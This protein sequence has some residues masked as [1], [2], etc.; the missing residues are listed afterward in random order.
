MALWELV[1]AW[2]SS[3]DNEPKSSIKPMKSAYLGPK[4]E[5]KDIE[6]A[7][8]DAKIDTKYHVVNQPSSA[9]IAKYLADGKI[10]ARFSGQM[11]FGQRALGNR[12]ILADPRRWDSVER[13]NSKIKYR[14]FWMPFTPSM[15]IEEAERL[16]INPKNYLFNFY[17]YGF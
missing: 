13:I 10:I 16:L 15:T 14:D 3:L 5:E 4:Y 17:D 9:S 8:S 2:L 1:A 12:S 11:E 7:L 6:F